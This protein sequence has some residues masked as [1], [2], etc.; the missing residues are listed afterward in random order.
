[1][2]FKPFDAV[3]G[4]WPKHYEMSR[5]VNKEC[6]SAALVAAYFIFMYAHVYSQTNCKSESVCKIRFGF[7]I[8][9]TI[10]I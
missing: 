4:E 2:N 5:K 3:I 1:M 6:G 10:F 8:C 9:S 7:I